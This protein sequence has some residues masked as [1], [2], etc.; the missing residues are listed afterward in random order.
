MTPPCTHMRCFKEMLHTAKALP[1]GDIP[2]PLDVLALQWYYMLLHKNNRNKF[3]AGKKLETKMLE[4]ITKFFEI[5]FKQNKV[6]GMLKRM[7]LKCMKARSSLIEEQALQ[8]D[9]HV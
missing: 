6:D 3:I 4:S 9:L 1:A 7:E 5:Q 8:Q 2:K